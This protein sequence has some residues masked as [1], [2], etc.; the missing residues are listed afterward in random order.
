MTKSLLYIGTYADS[1]TYGI[2][3][4]EVDNET[5]ALALLDVVK[6]YDCPTY[7]QLNT[8]G[9]KLYATAGL[10]DIPEPNGGL[11]VFRV[12]DKKLHF[13]DFEPS[14]CLA[15]CYVKVD[16][17]SKYAYAA[18]YREGEGTAY[19]LN[20]D[21]T[22]QKNQITQFVHHGQG[23]HPTRQEKAHIHCTELPPDEKI[24]YVV[25]LGIDTVKAYQPH[26]IAGKMVPISEA[27]LHCEAGSGPRHLRFNANGSRGYLIHELSSTVSVWDLENPR[28]PKRL[29]T[30]SILPDFF[31]GENTASAIKMSSDGTRLYCSNRGYD[32]IASLAIDP[33]SGLLTLLAISSTLGRGPRDFSILPG[34]KMIVVAH[35][36]TDTLI[37]LNINYETGVLTPANDFLTLE[38][39]PVCICVGAE[40]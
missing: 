5:G 27:D 10:P 12:E 20:S 32:S 11:A 18:S 3:I 29:Q 17:S 23:V 31:H 26:P 9:T 24:L 1:K 36:Y 4:V 2:P 7:L 39:Q 13:L 40:Y 34:E 14:H 22:F 37:C 8:D 28:A 35:Q 38:Q 15:P 33:K 16:Q 19:Q 6:G 25:D 21:G 30:L